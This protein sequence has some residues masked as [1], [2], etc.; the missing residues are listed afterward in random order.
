ML[1]NSIA[2]HTQPIFNRRMELEA[3][4]ERVWAI[5][6]EGAARAERRAEQTMLEVRAVTGMSRDRSGVRTARFAS[7]ENRDGNRDLT[8]FRDWWA[9][10]PD[11]FMRNMRE[12]WRKAIVPVQAA[13]KQSGEGLWLTRNNQRVFVAVSRQRPGSESWDFS[14]KPK[15]YE[16][17]VLLCWGEDL[18][19]HDFVVPQKLYVE[20]WTRAKKHGGSNNL[21]FWISRIEGTYFLQLPNAQPIDISETEGT[22]AIIG[23]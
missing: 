11:V 12:H 2:R 6:D 9:T 20:P 3:D 22:Y 15:S 23:E 7:K 1:G 8:S 10:A 13:L 5:L 14:V 17:L 19:L 18:V 16:I 21:D 4:P